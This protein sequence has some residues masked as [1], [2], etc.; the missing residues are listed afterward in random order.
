LLYVVRSRLLGQ[1]QQQRDCSKLTSQ[2]APVESSEQTDDKQ[3]QQQQQDFVDAVCVVILR[4]VSVL[5]PL[6]LQQHL[7]PLLQELLTAE[8]EDA[9]NSTAAA[10]AAAGRDQVARP[11]AAAAAAASA[12]A[13]GGAK[14]LG[15]EGKIVESAAVRIAAS[16]RAVLQ[17]LLWQM[18]LSKLPQ[19]QLLSAL[20]PLLLTAA[21]EPH[22]DGLGDNALPSPSATAISAGSQLQNAGKGLMGGT[23]QA[24]GNTAGVLALMPAAAAGKG[25]SAAVATAAEAASQQQQQCSSS[26]GQLA[27]SCL[28][29]LA[30]ALPFPVVCQFVL[31]PLLI[32]LPWAGS[33]SS[34]SS[35]SSSNSSVTA[36]SVACSF[37]LMNAQMNGAA[38]AL[39]AVGSVLPSRLAAE[40]VFMPVLHL[41]LLPLHS[42][43]SSTAAGSSPKA[44]PGSSSNS[45]R[46][47]AAA[48]G[49]DEDEAR[50]S[51]HTVAAL[52]VLEGLLA[53]VLPALSADA[54][55][56]A[57]D[58]VSSPN[59]AAAAAAAAAASG[60]GSSAFA[61]AAG[62]AGT[63]AGQVPLG[64]SNTATA[65]A[66]AGGRASTPPLPSSSSSSGK[67]NAASVQLHQLS[68]LLLQPPDVQAVHCSPLLYPRIAALLLL[69]LEQACESGITPSASINSSSSSSSS[70]ATLVSSWLLPQVLLPLLGPAAADAWQQRGQ[71][72]VRCYWRTVLLLYAAVVGQLGLKE[73]REAVPG[74]HGVEVRTC[75]HKDM[76][77]SS[78]N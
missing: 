53:R 74:W 67:R 60:S 3:Q 65:A 13:G 6:Q 12:A 54:V 78:A 49:S 58:K 48:A 5:T 72:V 18:L 16:R 47:S 19:Q 76:N 66:A 37:G 59:A 61:A 10:A 28:A 64:V 56:P 63:A 42:S 11:T 15:E 44:S 70:Y 38:Q 33:S 39:L 22:A 34:S 75:S 73:V 43:S 45:R 77:K 30:Q 20:L 23:V 57:L 55:L 69:A 7:L 50:V 21:L 32:A 9:G 51:T 40:F 31:R 52:P 46:S 24:T 68:L 36:S 8:S 71:A 17:P 62:A 27:A 1:Q 4:L 35:S 2:V 14:A 29:V 41:A 25:V 26:Q